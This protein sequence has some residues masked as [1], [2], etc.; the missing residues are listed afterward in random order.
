MAALVGSPFYLRNWI[1][2]G[3]PVF[4]SAW[5]LLGGEGWSSWRAWAWGEI[6]SN[7]GAGRTPLDNL[8]LPLRF[9]GTR[10]MFD[11]FEGSNGPILGIGL[12]AAVVVAWK[13]RGQMQRVRPLW[14]AL[15]FVIG[16]SVFWALSTQQMRFWLPALP[17][18]VAVTVAGLAGLPRFRAPALGLALLLSAAWTVDLERQV[19]DRQ[20]TGPWLVGAMDEDAVAAALMPDSYGIFPEVHSLVPPDGRIWL[21]WMRNKTYYLERDFRVDCIFEG[22][23]FEELLEAHEDPASLA[24]ALRLEGFTHMLIHHRFFLV[25]R[26]ADLEPGRTEELRKRFV[27]LMGAGVLSPVRRW[28]YIALYEVNGEAAAP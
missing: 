21:I 7:Y 2:R 16:F 6:L 28:D 15:G 18:L 5:S 4:P 3:N 8:L 19:W 9:F 13:L 20:H 26:N 17:V 22:W 25:G 27:A 1:Q 24:A 10:E 12:V 11:T 14:I 23:R